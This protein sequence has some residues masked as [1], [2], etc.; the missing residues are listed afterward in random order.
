MVNDSFKY[1]LN[2]KDLLK[3]LKGAG[4]AGGGAVV[5]FLIQLLPNVNW[6]SYAYLVVPV[7]GVLLNAAL[8]FFNGK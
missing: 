3:I 2:K 8:K 6:G 7:G 5:A 1:E 4:I